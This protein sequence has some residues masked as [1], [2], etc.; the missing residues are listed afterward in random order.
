M[1]IQFTHAT[2]GRSR[3]AIDT[4]NAGNHARLLLV[5]LIAASALALGTRANAQATAATAAESRINYTIPGGALARALLRFA[6]QSKLQVVYTADLTA[7]RQTS[8]LN[9]VFTPQEAL[10]KLL[11]GSGLAYRFTDDGSVTLQRASSTD[12]TR[13]L[14]PVKVEG[15]SGAANT[16]ETPGS[17]D[18]TA[19]EN[20]GSYT[21]GRL[22]VASRSPTSIKD[23]PQSV[24]VVTQQRMQDQNLTDFSTALSQT[25]GV[26]VV[27]GYPGALAM[28]FYSRG[29]ELNKLQ[30]DGGAPIGFGQSAGLFPQIDM[31][32]YDHVE[33]L[34][35]ADGV[36]N[37][38]G[39]PSGTI[40][41]ARKRPFDHRQVVVETQAGS[42]SNVRALVDATSPLG[43]DGRLRGR[44]VLS[45]QDQ[46]FFYDTASTN[47]T[48]AYGVLE[49][50]ASD[51]TLVRAGVNTL[52][53]DSVPW[54][55]GL[56][57]YAN[58]KDLNL[59]RSTCLC[60]KWNRW[61][62]E[63][64][65]LFAQADHDFGAG[66]TAKLNWSR[67]NQD[68]DLKAGH[69]S[70][71]V[72]DDGTGTY[73]VTE[74]YAYRSVQTTTDLSISGELEVLG[75][76][77]RLLIGG[78][79]QDM[80]NAGTGST[81]T[82]PGNVSTAVDVFH[83]DRNP[84][85][86]PATRE[87]N[88]YLLPENSAE[89]VGAY[90]T[91]NLQLSKAVHLIA[92]IRYSRYD[93]RLLNEYYYEGQIGDRFV[94]RFSDDEISWPPH[95]SLTYDLSKNVLA[96]ASYTDIY[97]TQGNMVDHALNPIE[98]V[99]GSNLEAGVKFE[100]RDGRLN[101]TVA[102]YRVEQKHLA[103][104]LDYGEFGDAFGSVGNGIRCCYS[105]DSNQVNLSQGFDAE[106]TGELLP[107]WQVFAGY[108]YNSNSYKG[109]D[110]GSDKGRPLV[111]LSPKHLLKL[112]T[113]YRLRGEGMLGRLTVGG[114]IN[115]Q[116]ST[117][118]AGYSCLEFTYLEEYDYTY[119][120]NSIPFE[121]TEKSY[122]VFS[123]RLQYQA[124][125][126]W[127]AAL[128]INNITDRR[129]YQTV[130]TPMGANWYGEPR[131]VMLTVRG[132]F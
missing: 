13:V 23:T 75:L 34:R 56:P 114:G 33:I 120:S 123:G 14:G 76:T 9:G 48:I 82:D 4:S 129:Y 102:V 87:L 100:G 26:T 12:G 50:D 44:T 79:Y 25:T 60:T 107:G 53:Q 67:L 106:I 62:F 124:S 117:Y 51:S 91:L 80:N 6:E 32:T 119:C 105:N 49:L 40:N 112:W 15:Q 47:K 54:L 85:E 41:L 64:N 3:M 27:T 35:G 7:G 8:G 17:S 130:G 11:E 31:A 109:D 37:G 71:A 22:S 52:R 38:Y 18:A 127:T 45:Y 2:L 5:A 99:T 113:T 57:R 132:Q 28:S 95:L 30:L 68:S 73:L 110:A 66:W 125:N 97:Q 55:T 19:T 92:G 118:S 63:T 94:S 111:S 16:T 1:T 72:L 126:R 65:E 84:Y 58:G 36:L 131:S 115:A 20:S 101:A 43:F 46:N 78:S 122:A 88:G 103:R 121:F 90:A 86:P 104:F 39:D 98:P 128:N 83:F 96:Y 42:W 61:N 69:S 116:S 21:S 93:R 77:Q 74:Q 59:P 89:Q 70:N 108:T 24:S 10:A 29:F 81:G